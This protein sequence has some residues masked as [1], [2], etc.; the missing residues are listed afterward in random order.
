M[1]CW[2]LGAVSAVMAFGTLKLVLSTPPQ[3]H[4]ATV[5]FD[6]PDWLDVLLL[7]AAAVCGV[8]FFAIRRVLWRP[9]RRWGH[10]RR[11]ADGRLASWASRATDRQHDLHTLMTGSMRGGAEARSLL[12]PQP[13]W[14]N[15]SSYGLPPRPAWTALQEAL[16]DWRHGRR[17]WEPWVDVVV[18]SAAGEPGRSCRV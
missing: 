12:D 14:L 17:S 6:G 3:E 4:R 13:G 10:R 8:A 15:T 9:P 1:F 18:T 11:C 5:R 2:L 16:D 7:T